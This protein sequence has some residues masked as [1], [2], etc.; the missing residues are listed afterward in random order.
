MTREGFLT[1]ADREA[2]D[3]FPAVVDPNDVDRCFWLTEWD[4]REVVARRYGAAGRLSAGLQIGGLRLLGFVPSEL[5]SAP[6]EVIGFVAGQVGAEVGDAASYSVRAHTR[7]DHIASVERH[8][9]YRRPAPGDLKSLGDWLVERALEHDRPIVLF[10]LMCDHLKAERIVRPGVTVLERLVGTARQRAIEETWY[11]LA[12]HISSEQRRALDGLLQ[13]DPALRITPLVWF[14]QEASTALP[15]MIQTQLNKLERLRDLGFDPAVVSALNPNR[16][17]HLSRLG[18]RMSPQALRRSAPG[19]RYQILIATLVET[20]YSLTDEIIG[21]FDAA[22]GN[23]ERRARTQLEEIKR[24]TATEA[25]RAVR[26]FTQLGRLVLD[27]AIP[28]RQL[29]ERIFDLISP[30]PLAEAIDTAERIARPADGNYIDLLAARYAQVRRYAPPVLGSFEF[31]AAPP[32]APLLE[33]LR[34]LNMLNLA[35]SRRVPAHAPTGFAPTAWQR[36]LTNPQGRTDRRTW[37]L[38][39]L[40]QTRAALRGGN[41]WVNHSRRYQNPAKY[42]LPDDAWEVLRPSVTTETGISLDGHHRTAELNTQLQSHISHLNTALNNGRKV[43]TKNGRLVLTP[44]T[45]EH[46]EPKNP[47]RDQIVALLPELDLVDLLAEVNTWCGFLDAFSHAG[48]STERTPNHT[49]RLLAVLV[50]NGCNLG[51][52]AMARSSGFSPRQLAW[53]QNWYFRD[54]TVTAANTLIVNHQHAHP[55]AKTWGTGTLSSSDGQRFPFTVRNPTAR[56]MRRY[57]TRTGGTIYTW[58]SDQHT[59]YGTRVIPTTIREATYVLDAILDNE[60]DL[61][62]DEHTTDTAGYTDLIFGLFDLTGLTFSPR[63]RDLANQRLWRLPT[64]PTNTPAAQFLRHRINPQR[65]L[66][67]WDDLL[68]VAATIRHGHTPAS[69]LISRLQASARQNDLTRAIQ[70]YGRIIKT[71]SVLRYLHNENHRRRVHQQL[72]KGE[73]LH[74]LRRQLFFANLGRLNRRRPDDQD[75]QA[76]C[77]T[78]LTNAVITWN[79]TCLGAAIDHLSPTVPASIDHLSPTVHQH[80]NLYGRYDFT[81]P[82]T[83]PPGQLRPLRHHP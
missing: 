55:L 46:A 63:I 83:P 62:I 50:A 25:N 67:R 44:L 58:T 78:L 41:L 77:L 13:I 65:F 76:H 59:Q 18:R 81:N 8:L 56:A 36:H 42:L 26:L 21:L 73:S 72:N 71:I 47:L 34:I 29:R 22:L 43:R 75:L 28:D 33:A 14:R 38:C 27:D 64:T 23:V 54:A 6:E 51:L 68:R 11:K 66:D 40:Y 49:S 3:R 30:Q 53:T 48:H 17:R 35:R 57:Y 45:A 5:L 7:S 1:R 2:L 82:T 4:R 39:I 20:T 52:A 80:I 12:P 16:V 32:N 61:D 70:Q 37:E 9:G 74:A 10:R 69:L 31:D 24:S 15:T 79:T 60:T 19:R